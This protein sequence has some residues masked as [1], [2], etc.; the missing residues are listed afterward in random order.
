MLSFVCWLVIEASE[1]IGNV[2][3]TRLK[4][5]GSLHHHVQESCLPTRNNYSGLLHEHRINSCWVKPLHFFVAAN[6]TFAKT[7]EEILLFVLLGGAS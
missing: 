4:E 3:V 2:R 5:Y 6:V 1:V 7:G